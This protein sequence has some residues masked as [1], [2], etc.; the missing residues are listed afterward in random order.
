MSNHPDDAIA[1]D[2][3]VR[4]PSVHRH[5][6]D[7]VSVAFGVVF[8]IAGL[9]FLLADVDA[10]NIGSPGGWIALLGALG[11]LLVAMGARRHRR[12]P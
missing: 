9:V 7:I 5:D 6:L 3:P 4:E 11:I 2:K 1:I 8:A 12:E 10:S